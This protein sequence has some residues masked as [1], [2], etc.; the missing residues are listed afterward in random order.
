MRPILSSHASGQSP[1]Q[2]MHPLLENWLYL[3]SHPY[4]SQHSQ[5]RQIAKV[6]NFGPRRVEHRQL[7]CHYEAKLSQRAGGIQT[8]KADQ[9]S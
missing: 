6:I 9:P 8:G 7:R 2:V 1:K 5:P 3:Q 4:L